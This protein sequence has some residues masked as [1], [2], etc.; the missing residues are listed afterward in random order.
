MVDKLDICY[1]R[2]HQ[3]DKAGVVDPSSQVRRYRGDTLVSETK[4]D[5]RV[6]R[7]SIADLPETQGLKLPQVCI[8]EVQHQGERVGTCQYWLTSN[9][10]Q[11]QRLG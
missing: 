2:I 6:V 10:W 4:A 1:R 9:H 5:I 11:G 3:R 7:V 8:L